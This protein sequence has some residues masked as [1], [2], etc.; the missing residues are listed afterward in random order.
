MKSVRYGMIGCGMMG[1]EHLRNIAL[2]PDAEVMAI[3]EP[4][5]GMRARAAVLA[6][7]A[8]FVGSLAEVLATEAVNCLLSPDLPNSARN[9]PR[10]SGWRWN[11]ATCRQS[12]I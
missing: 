4:D 5:A 1:Q 12:P 9:I 6:P 3:F 10:R 2:L 8:R 11:T 7:Q